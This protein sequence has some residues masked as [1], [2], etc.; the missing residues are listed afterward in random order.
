VS[1][2]RREEREIQP[3][4][5]Y[6]AHN[7]ALNVYFHTSKITA[8]IPILKFLE[9]QQKKKFPKMSLTL[10]ALYT[11]LGPSFFGVML[12]TSNKDEKIQ[13]KI[14]F[15]TVCPASPSVAWG[16]SK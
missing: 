5:L 16:R 7:P 2:V 14:S 4:L 3:N 8:R 10:K 15:K 6:C 12:E 11:F 9:L 13:Q 1:V